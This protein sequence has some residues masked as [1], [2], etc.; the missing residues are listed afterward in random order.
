MSIIIHNGI[1]KQANLPFLKTD[2]RL[3][4]FGDGLFE[5]IRII[6]GK[7]VNLENHMIRLFA[8]MELLRIDIPINYSKDYF[9]KQILML[10]SKNEIKKG[11]IARLTVYRDSPGNY[12]PT[13][14][15]AGFVL[16]VKEYKDNKYT[17][18][19]NGLTIDVYEAVKKPYSTY[20]AFKTSN[21]M[22][23]ILATLYAKE[24]NLDDVLLLNEKDNIIEGSSSNVFI[25]SNGVLY[26]PPIAEGSVGGTMRMFLINSAIEEGIKVYETNLTPQN[27]LAADEILFTNAVKGIQWVSS[28]KSKRYFNDVAKKLTDLIN[29][30][31]KS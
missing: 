22:L 19:K 8:G 5:S 16:E 12:F 24:N 31:A 29:K 25:V 23:Y 14:N 4:K 18:N 6:N 7:P 17:L 3:F 10:C 21:A 11:G 26:T 13:E 9:E 30:K 15:T 28:Y 20:S 27:F 2:N 1:E